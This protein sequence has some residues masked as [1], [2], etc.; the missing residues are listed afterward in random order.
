MINM[1]YGRFSNSLLLLASLTM[2]T[3]GISFGAASV[4]AETEEKLRP[5][6]EQASTAREIVAKLEVLHYNKLNLNDDMSTKLWHEYIE[7]LDP[8]KSYFTAADIGEFKGWRTTLDDA[9]RAGNIDHGFAIF[10]RYRE[11]VEHRLERLLGEL[12]NGLP[13]YDYTVDES[14]DLD[15]KDNRWPANSAEADELWRKRLKSSVLNLKLADKTDEEIRDLLEK[16]YSGQ[17]KSLRQQDGDDAFEVY[18]NSL[19]RLYDPHSNYLSPRTL[20]NFNINM[21]LSLEGI[22]AVLQTEDEYTKIVRLVAGGPADRSGEVKPAD[23]IV[24]V[25]EGKS[26][27]LVDVVGW[28]LDDVVELIRGDADSYVRL[29]VIPAGGDGKQKQV[30]IQRKK[31]KLE[32]QAAKKEVFE[33]SDGDKLYKVGVINLPT[34]YIDFEAYRRRDPNYKSTTRDVHRLLKELQEENVD[35][36]VLDLRNNGGGSLQEATML[37]DLFIDQGPVVQIRHANEKI[38]RHSRSRSRAVY[39]GPLVVLINRLSA[40]ASEIFAGA[41][42]DYNRGLIVGTQ[43]FGK[44][45]VQTMAP[46]KE[47]QLKIT[48]S[49][50]YRVSGE[51]TQHAGVTPDIYMPP[52]VDKE[53]VGESAYDT[54]LPWDRIH[55]VQHAKYFNLKAILPALLSNHEQRLNKDP[56]LVYLKEQFDYD[57]SRSKNKTLSLNE[58]ERLAEREEYKNRTLEIENARRTA[59]GLPPYLTFEELEKSDSEDTA[60]VGGPVDISLDDDPILSETGNIL[61]DLIN[62]SSRLENAPQVANF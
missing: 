31:V 57:L 59:K 36:I 9:I 18:M 56:D 26:G 20:E 53:M 49:K 50:F 32:D 30:T 1:R 11:R 29:E 6:K 13:N 22:G 19:T 2:G 38:S 34:F 52:M 10:N 5:T 14:L 4:L 35:G 51:S 44:G 24:A 28:R 54:A 25:G 45:T 62:M 7:S 60:P 55:E 37:T 33:Y 46:L 12:R 17:L 27:E 21:S 3:L 23:K 8:T 41:I 16:R 42:Q 40:S 47:G 15:R 43:S 61:V 58:E 48:Q 39:R